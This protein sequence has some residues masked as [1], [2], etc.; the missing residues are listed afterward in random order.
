MRGQKAISVLNIFFSTRV[1]E[2]SSNFE[3]DKNKGE[4]L[5]TIP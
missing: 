5:M 4:K 3:V 1:T 2:E